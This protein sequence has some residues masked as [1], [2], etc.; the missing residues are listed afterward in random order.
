[1]AVS[2]PGRAIDLN[3]DL[4]EGCPWD[5]ALLDRVTSASVCCG[6]HAGDPETIRRTLRRAR[7]R[8]VAVGAHPGFADRAGFGRREQEIAPEAVRR[9]ILAQWDDLAALA[10][11]DGVILRFVKPHGALYNQAQRDDAIA[12]GVVA[13]VAALGCPV[14]GQPGSRLEALARGAGLPFIAEGFADRRYR[15]DGRLVPRTEPGAVLDDPAEIEAQ[16]LRLVA[17]G[18]VA[19]ICLHGDDPR[20]VELADLVRSILQGGGLSPRSF[21]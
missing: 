14:L 10:A 2:E 8:G 5:E 18:T 12:S 9:L 21:A 3:A 20:S 4:G 11:A 16:V 15:D 7:A 1:M 13:A 19:T 17:Q 6:A